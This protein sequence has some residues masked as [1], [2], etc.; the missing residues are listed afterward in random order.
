[1][2]LLRFY[3]GK[4]GRAAAV[5]AWCFGIRNLR[6]LYRMIRH[7]LLLVSHKRHIVHQ[8]NTDTSGRK[9]SSSEFDVPAFTPWTIFS[10]Y[11]TWYLTKAKSC[12][13]IAVNEAR[14]PRRIHKRNLHC[15]SIRWREIRRGSKTIGF[16]CECGHR[17][18][19]RRP[20]VANTS[21][22]QEN[23]GDFRRVMATTLFMR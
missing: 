23:S 7:S 5:L 8:S 6:Y 4:E 13:P 16:E 20:I 22:R 3:H 12:V 2:S 21:S 18:I 1:M 14:I 10:L 9:R 11:A 17:Y 15:Q 19:Q